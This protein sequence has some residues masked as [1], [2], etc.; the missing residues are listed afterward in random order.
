MSPPTPPTLQGRKQPSPRPDGGTAPRRLVPG[1]CECGSRGQV[2][3]PSCGLS[4][5]SSQGQGAQTEQGRFPGE[6]SRR[7]RGGVC[8]S[9]FPYFRDTYRSVCRDPALRVRC[10]WELVLE[11]N[12]VGDGQVLPSR[13]APSPAAPACAEG[14]AK[15]DG[16]EGP[17]PLTPGRSPASPRL[18]T[19]DPSWLSGPVTCS[20]DD[21]IAVPQSSGSGCGRG[22]S[23]LPVSTMCSPRRLCLYPDSRVL[24]RIVPQ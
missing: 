19:P 11:R 21:P 4:T 14:A 2:F 13:R 1:L 5:G 12:G 8:T 24:P 10:S 17:V 3:S 18:T 6:R 20:C 7:Q 15:G 22:F 16:V 9:V 23:G